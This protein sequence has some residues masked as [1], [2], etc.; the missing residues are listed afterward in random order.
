MTP[1]DLLDFA[2]AKKKIPSSVLQHIPGPSEQL[3]KRKIVLAHAFDLITISWAS[4]FLVKFF[5]ASF[6]SF[7][8][9]RELRGAFG[10]IQFESLM[11]TI[12]PLM[13]TSYFFFSFFFNQ[14]QSWGMKRMKLR[15]T[16][17]T[18]SYR[19]SL[20]WAMFSACAMMTAGLTLLSYAWI[21]KKGWGEFKSE[22]Y[23]YEGLVQYKDF[24]ALNLV[25]AAATY[26]NVATLMPKNQEK[27]DSIYEAA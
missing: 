9:T 25:E 16:I 20:L 6:Q 1:I 13:F 14:G 22:D 11:I 5:E 21:Q 2:Q 7:M 3:K 12:M 10:Q 15:V 26:I 19:S 4:L 24:N 23:L 8:V 17:P 27:E 18:F